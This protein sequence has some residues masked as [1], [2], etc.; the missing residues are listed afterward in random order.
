MDI[1]AWADGLTPGIDKITVILMSPNPNPNPNPTP[2]PNPNS[3]QGF[4]EELGV[5]RPPWHSYAGY[6][7]PNPN[8]NLSPNPN[9]NPNPNPNPNPNYADVITHAVAPAAGRG[10]ARHLTPTLTPP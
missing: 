3:R 4:F 7:N 8:R 6:P 10:A 5:K 2:N 1:G 9:H